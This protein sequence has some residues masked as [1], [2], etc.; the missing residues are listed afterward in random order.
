MKEH[1]LD[2]NEL[3][4]AYPDKMNGRNVTEL[5]EEEICDAGTVW[6]IKKIRLRKNY[7]RNPFHKGMIKRVQLM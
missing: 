5:K 1:I 2:L 7:I 3:T 4:C 6:Y